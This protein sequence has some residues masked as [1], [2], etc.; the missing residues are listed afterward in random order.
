MITSPTELSNIASTLQSGPLGSSLRIIAVEQAYIPTAPVYLPGTA[1]TR[2]AD[3]EEIGEEQAERAAAVLG[4]LDEV[5]DV[6]R[7]WTNVVGLDS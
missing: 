2:P 3:S 5:A 1:T 7:V 4:S 6:Q